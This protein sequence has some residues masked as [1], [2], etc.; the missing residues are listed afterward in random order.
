[1][2]S[3][4]VFL[5]PWWLLLLPFGAL[6]AY[7]MTRSPT[8][9]WRRVCDARLLAALLAGPQRSRLLLTWIV[10][11]GGW[12]M[13]VLALSGPAWDH[14]KI[15][16]Y[17]SVDA[18][19]VVF[20]LSRSMNANDVLPSRIERARYKAL[21]LVESMAGRAIGL[22][23]FAGDAHDV[24]P[25]SDDVA[26][27]IHLIQSL[28][29]D[30]MPLQGSNASEGLRRAGNL[31]QGS[32]YRSGTVILLT[33]GVDRA[34]HAAAQELRAAGYRLS[35]IGIGSSVGAPVRF[36]SG[37]YLRDAADELIIASVDHG[38]LREL[39][40][41]GGGRYQLMSSE[42]A[43]LQALG[44]DADFVLQPL[45]SEQLE[46]VQ[47]RDRGAWLALALL[48]LAAL[49]FRRGWLAAAVW[50]F[51]AGPDDAAALEWR[52]LWQRS[53]Q[54]AAAAVLAGE[55]AAPGIQAHPSWHGI[56]RYRLAD[57]DQA[58]QEFSKS[59][60]PVSHYNHGNALAR[61]GDLPA[62]IRQYQRALELDSEFQDAKFNLDLLQQLLD[63]Q[64][65]RQSGQ[66][67]QKPGQGDD[68]E[69]ANAGES[70]A[71]AAPQEPAGGAQPQDEENLSQAN[72]PGGEQPYGSS[73]ETEAA[74]G[75][76]LQSASLPDSELQTAMREEQLQAIEQLLRQVKADPGGL[77][78]RKFYYDSHSRGSQPRETQPW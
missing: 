12:A 36:A 24:T 33:D 2:F 4:L 45:D 17:Q 44:S 51:M 78:R 74:S 19:I 40:Q 39:A 70:D 15:P 9:N 43:D 57:F 77:L 47:W 42:P 53:D 29:T 23:A 41:A 13:A 31:L 52:D 25:V 10:T 55:Y 58:A 73:D 32:G 69:P 35:V 46:T 20:D 75:Q 30:I 18:T 63:R 7:W 27:V 59:A 60:D 5:R 56:A 54:R 67:E 6:L 72:E 62:A 28:R 11:A 3:E 66:S 14:E 26:T 64:L 48:P 34:A 37:D 50:V 16:L 38:S 76:D 21:E 8:D 22:V 71:Q 61:A 49:L 68:S 1:M 65:Q